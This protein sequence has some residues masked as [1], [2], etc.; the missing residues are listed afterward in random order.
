VEEFMDDHAGRSCW[1]VATWTVVILGG[2]LFLALA[3]GDFGT[4]AVAAK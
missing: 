4:V 2:V 1:G 3:L